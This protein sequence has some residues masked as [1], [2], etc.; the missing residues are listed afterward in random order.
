MKRKLATILLAAAAVLPS[1]NA[2]TDIDRILQSVE[3]NNLTLEALLNENKSQKYANTGEVTLPDPEVGFS[4]LWGSPADAGSKKQISATQSFD[5]S[6]LL[7]HKGAVARSQN[8]LLD[9]EYRKVR[10]SILL[11]AK[12]YCYQVIY[13]NAVEAELGRQLKNTEQLVEAY[14]RVMD[15]G[16]TEQL[17]YNRARLAAAL[18]KGELRKN[19]I[20]RS[21]AL[22]QLA[23]LNG[24]NAVTLTDTSFG[25]IEP[26][27]PFDVWYARA[28]AS[29]PELEYAA[30]IV[31]LRNNE[32]RLGKSAWAP[33]ITA[34]YEAELEPHD[35][36]QGIALGISLPLWGGRNRI[37]QAKAATLAA[38]SREK[39]VRNTLYHDMKYLYDR[40]QTLQQ[41]VLML[42]G[43]YAGLAGIKTLERNTALGN[44]SFVE[45]QVEATMY[46]EA[47]MQILSEELEYYR[48]FAELNAYAL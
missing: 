18:L 40:T 1:A 21:E 43:E 15:E 45:F 26:L 7:G 11:E 10:R 41:N 13:H 29:D 6:T 25:Q 48:S 36:Y 38:Q 39:E 12:K 3:S 33:T 8:A 4:Y 28:V 24:G 22:T 20:A 9:I 35:T 23:K 46:Y 14:G 44:M 37:K 32:V 17:E 30:R 27:P 31:Q 47:M 2:Q 42:K 5:F 16:G 34:G 19:G